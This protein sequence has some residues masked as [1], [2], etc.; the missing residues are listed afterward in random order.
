MVI[1]KPILICNEISILLSPPK[2]T[3]EDDLDLQ[4]S[5]D[6]TDIMTE[7]IGANKY[8]SL[9]GIFIEGIK[10]RHM[11]RPG[12]RNINT[13]VIKLLCKSATPLIEALPLAEMPMTSAEDSQL[14]H[15]KNIDIKTAAH[16]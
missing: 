6:T 14:A 15:G 16:K 11:S 5:I 1:I 4:S 3:E 13:L 10:S 9:I 12:I 7:T 2:D 8:G